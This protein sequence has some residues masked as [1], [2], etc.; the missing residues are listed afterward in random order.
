MDK[1]STAKNLLI[2]ITNKY[3][4]N[5]INHI[6]FSLV[7]FFFSSDRELACSLLVNQCFFSFSLFH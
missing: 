7:C 1:T 6:D 2:K 3:L 4:I 5:F